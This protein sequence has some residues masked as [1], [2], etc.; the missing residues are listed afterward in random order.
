[1]KRLYHIFAFCLLAALFGACNNFDG[2]QE[3]P[4]YI[5]VHGFRMVS[6]PGFAFEQGE[7]FLTSDITDVWVYVD[8]KYVGAYSLPKDGSGALIPILKKGRHKIDLQPGVKYNGMAGTR[9]YYRFYTYNTEEVELKQG[10]IV[11]MGIKDVMY[12]ASATFS[13]SYFFENGLTSFENLEKGEEPQPNN[14]S[15]ISGDS[16][17]Y[18]SHCLAMYSTS[19][20]DSYRVMSKDSVT[21]T[22]RNGI[23]LELDYCSNI[24]F[25]VGI[26]GKVSAST[27]LQRNISAMRIKPTDGVQWKKIY[28]ILGKVWSQ[29][30]YQPFKIYFQPFNPSGLGNG[31][32]HID[33]IKVV[34]YP[35]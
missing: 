13:F 11:D 3:I 22:N 23:I 34:H 19:N 26:Y 28:I 17:R 1:M 24:P 25:E 4:S 14:F 7:D 15:I 27:S 32:V 10:E 31:F 20:D 18:G 16:V 30:S 9:D 33:N 35:D 12:N 2:D 8:Q 5:R 29:N 21:T 6:N